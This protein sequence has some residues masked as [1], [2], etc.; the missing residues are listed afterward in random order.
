MN[1]RYNG[2]IEKYIIMPNHIH[3]AIL[4]QSGGLGNPPLQDIVGRMK[5]YTTKRYNQILHTENKA[6]WQRSF[7]DHIIR[8]ENEYLKVWQYIDTNPL[9]WQEDQYYT[10]L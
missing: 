2:T 5:S 10:T 7:Y 8:D 3:M 1:G 9:K 6:L 4:L